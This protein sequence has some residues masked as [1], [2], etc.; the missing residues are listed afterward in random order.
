MALIG[1]QIDLAGSGSCVREEKRAF[2]RSFEKGIAMIDVIVV[3]VTL[4]AFLAL[5]GLTAGCERL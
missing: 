4:I 3:L 5:I 1:E 2:P